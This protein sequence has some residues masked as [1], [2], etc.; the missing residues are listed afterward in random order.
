MGRLELDL[1]GALGLIGHAQGAAVFVIE[2]HVLLS[3]LLFS[4]EVIFKILHRFFF[5]NF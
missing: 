2:A 4:L 3:D 1:F 5:Q